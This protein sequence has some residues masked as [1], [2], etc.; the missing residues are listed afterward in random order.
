[1]AEYLLAY[2]EILKKEQ[3]GMLTKEEAALRDSIEDMIIVSYDNN[4]TRR[5][6]DSEY[7]PES[8]I[9][10]EDL[11]MPSYIGR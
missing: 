7:V 3:N 1:M 6:A 2:K 4:R 10:T 5:F 8:G 9:Y 11:F